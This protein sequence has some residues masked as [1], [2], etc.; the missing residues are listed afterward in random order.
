MCVGQEPAL[1]VVSGELKGNVK[2]E[3]VERT[4]V[5][6]NGRNVGSRHAKIALFE[7]TTDGKLA[8]TTEYGNGEKRTT[9]SRREGKLK[10]EVQY[11]D[12][13]GDP[14]TDEAPAFVPNTN[15]ISE[16]GLCSK[17]I[18]RWD[19][20]PIGK[21]KREYEVCL[22]GAERSQTTSEFDQK[23]ELVREKRVDSKLRWWESVFDRDRSGNII[24]FNY[25]VND[26]VKPIYTQTVKYADYKF[27][28]HGNWT[29]LVATSFISTHPGR[30]AYQFHSKRTF[31]YFEK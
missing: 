10:A 31:T 23:D 11:F 8:R 21:I 30:L 25:T 22:D 13:L 18:V 27:D 17:F 5:V 3:F 14:V 1:R 28:R 29:S 16:I 12:S 2:T 6:M 15:S 7:Y 9:Y 4:Y 20:D 26:T 24:E 19:D